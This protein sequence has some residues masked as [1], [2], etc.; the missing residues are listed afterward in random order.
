MKV[1]HKKIKGFVCLTDWNNIDIL[2]KNGEPI[3]IY[4]D[5]DGLEYIVP[6]RTR[7]IE[8]ELLV[9]FK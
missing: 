1:K 4:Q 7:I 8:C 9:K 6:K 5:R 3:E 2:T